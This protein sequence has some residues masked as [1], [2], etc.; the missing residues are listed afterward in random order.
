M[1]KSFKRLA[2]LNGSGVQ[3]GAL[4]YRADGGLQVLLVTSRETRR[5]TIPKGWPIRRLDSREAAAREALEEAGVSG[6]V[7]KSAMGVYRYQK[8]LRDGCTVLCSVEVFPLEVTQEDKHW[9]EKAQRKR[10]WFTPVEAADLVEEPG[11]KAL[12][13]DFDPEGAG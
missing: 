1:S 3:Y 12:I 4:P 9:V 7:G 2:R 10:A 6:A 13:L 11:L 5:W 8:R